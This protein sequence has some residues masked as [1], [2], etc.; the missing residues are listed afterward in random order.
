MQDRARFVRTLIGGLVLQMLAV[1]RGLALDPRQ[2]A[3]TYLRADFTIEDGLPDNC[4][5]A[6][7]QTRNGFLWVGTGGGLARFDGERFTQIRLRA[8]GSRQIP[9]NSL[10][11]APD[12]ELWVGTDAGLARI[13]SG[14]LDHFDR[15]LVQVYHPG[16][17]LSDQVMCLRRSHDGVLWVGTNRGLY[18]FDQ[19]KIVTVIPG[20]MVSAVEEALD[21]RLLIITGHGFVEWDGSRMTP[22]RELPGKL[23]VGANEIYHV[24]QDRQGVTWFCTSAG[25][26]RRV[27]GFFQKLS[28]YRSQRPAFRV[29]EDPQGNVWTNTVS[30]L[31]RAGAS[32]LEPVAG[33]LQVR[34][35][36]SDLDGEL[37]LG[38]AS[39][40]LVR[41]KD[42]AFRMYTAADGLPGNYPMAVLTSHDGTLW[43]GSNCG[44]ISRFDGRRF[45]TYDRRD[46]LS[47]SCVWSMA[48]GADHDLWIGTWG[49]GL[50]RFRDGR[51]ISYS[52]A[53]GLPSEVVFS[54]ATAR[55]G[56]LWIATPEG[57]SHMQNGNFRN[58]TMADGLSS[59]RII[60]V[61]QDPA[62]GIWAGTS[63]GVDRLAGDRFVPVRPGAESGRIPYDALREDSS[64]NLYALSL[65][66]GISRIEDNRLVSVND[67]LEP[68][69]MIES[70]EHHFWFSGRNG[71][72]RV[73]AAELKRGQLDRDAP[74]DY[75]SFGRADGLNSIECSKGQ[76]NMAITPGDKLW[77]GTVKGLAMLDLRRIPHRN[78][79]PAIF[80]EDVE[81]GR[82]KRAPGRELVLRPGTYH[83]GLHFTAVDLASPE[84]IRI[85]YRLDGVD[86][87]WL[88][89]NSTRTATYTDIP[90]GV[91]AFHIRASNGDGVWD[92]EGIVYNISQ[93]P[94]LYETGGFRLAA[95]TAGFLLLAGVYRFRL[96][97]ATERLNARFEERVA[98]RNRLAAELHDTIL[99]TVQA[100]KMI[101]DNARYDH[102]A[103]LVRLREAIESVSDWLAQATSEARGALNA[104]RAS[105][106]PKNDLAEA[107][108][109]AAETSKA[110]SSMRFVLSTEGVAEEIHPIVRDE[111]YRIC[112]EAIRNACL[113]SEATE[114]E[115]K[116]IYAQNLTVRVR[117]NG[118]G[119]DPDVAKHGKPGH[120]GLRGMKERAIRIQGSLRLLSRLGSGTEIELIVPGNVVF[121]EPAASRQT[122]PATLRFFVH[123]WSPG[124]AIRRANRKG[125]TQ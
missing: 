119:I 29:Y 13:P 116:L 38:T 32:G 8:G 85:Q 17:G 74:L 14:A 51:F 21:G 124:P 123:G 110:T 80:M 28:P 24:F 10:L 117:D 26:A 44:G 77:V 89:A 46:G 122:L 19:G 57:M 82:E 5:N 81:V 45:H 56:S 111:I 114:L 39:V 42:H 16:V 103:D 71:L 20:E 93:E 118:K 35:M 68:S 30:G 84:N 97:Q 105:T 101:A 88:D 102:A 27:K 73:A 41:L 36:Y 72:F 100:T 25:V 90:V 94:Y 83:V 22:H 12:G 43:V 99:Q 1:C 104:L 112:C 67:A 115:L 70:G 65:A 120:F 2:P 79:K 61:Y 55:D 47:N 66:N 18:R 31:F 64:G 62:G 50:N 60:S 76:P 121:R 4:V 33:A 92:R 87:L 6:I 23:D 108:Q 96:R 95:V 11:T 107:F 15:A 52:R 53:Q 78:R 54:I 49:G 113:H 69:G 58:Y 109:R 86:P 37:W 98:E 91:H 75:L 106:T 59:D 125:G 9:V 7:L 63:A 48:E 3:N 34:C 40:G